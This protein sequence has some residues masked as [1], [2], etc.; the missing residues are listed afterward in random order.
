MKKYKCIA[1]GLL[2]GDQKKQRLPNLKGLCR[3][4]RCVV[5]GT[6]WLIWPDTG[7]PL[8]DYFNRKT[9]VQK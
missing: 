2:P 4:G 8:E 5:H 6:V 9:L 7:E 1:C 3:A